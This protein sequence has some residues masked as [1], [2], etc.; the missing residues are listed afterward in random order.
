MSAQSEPSN[1]NLQPRP[2]LGDAHALAEANR[3]QGCLDGSCSTGCPLD[4]D[5]NAFVRRITTA[6]ATG[7]YRSLRAANPMPETTALICPA[8]ALCQGHCA[9]EHLGHAVNISLLQ[10]YVAHTSGRTT[11]R[12][13]PGPVTGLPLSVTV[14]SVGWMNPANRFK[15]VVLPHPEAP[16]ATTKSPGPIARETFSRA[17]TPAPSF[18]G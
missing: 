17:W 13:A 16:R 18:V 6:N 2:V 8:E 4:V 14:P 10:R 9:S 5:V 11:P 3:C 15:K 7:A 12:S 1:P